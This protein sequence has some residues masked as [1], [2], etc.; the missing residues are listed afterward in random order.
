VSLDLAVARTLHTTRVLERALHAPDAP[1]RWT[2][3]ID[4]LHLPVVREVFADGVCFTTHAPEVC[5]TG[6]V[7]L[8]LHHDGELLDCRELH[9]ELHE[10]TW[11]LSLAHAPLAA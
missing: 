2:I 1:G 4:G 7:L 10:I 11:E 9:G 5:F 3:S 6:P 8:G